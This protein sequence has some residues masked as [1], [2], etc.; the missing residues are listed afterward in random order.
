MLNVTNEDLTP[1]HSVTKP[2]FLAEQLEFHKLSLILRPMLI[3]PLV[4]I[5][6]S[7]TIKATIRC[8]I[9]Q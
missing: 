7:G 8:V 4:A 2:L 9:K 6:L 5:L 3:R 1:I